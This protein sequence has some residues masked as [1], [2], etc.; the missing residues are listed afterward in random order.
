MPFDNTMGDPMFSMGPIIMT[1]FCVVF[2]GG[3]L[4]TVIKGIG[5]WSSNNAQPVLSVFAKVVTKRT[6]IS[7]STFQNADGIPQDSSTTHYYV[8]FQV[9]SGDR[10]EFTITGKE[11]GMLADDD[12]GKLTFQGTRYLGFVRA[13][14]V[15]GKTLA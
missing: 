14:V 6:H 12:E 5:Q 13:S 8:T 1:L 3:I 11:Y 15:L 4:F 9:E 10:M 2:F 7:R